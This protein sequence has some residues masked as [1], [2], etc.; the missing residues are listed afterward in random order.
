ME[1]L[2][3][4]LVT[5]NAAAMVSKV[6]DEYLDV[7]ALEPTLYSLNMTDSFVAYNDSGLSE[8]AIRAYISHLCMGLMSLVRVMGVLPII[9]APGG[10]PAEM[11]ANDLCGSLRDALSP[12]SQAHSI[13]GD[14]LVSDRPRP[15]LL[16]LDRVSDLT[17][18][19]MHASTY[20]ALVD[21]LLGLKLNKVTVSVQG[22]DQAAP[23]KKTYDLNS[24][25]DPFFRRYASAPFPEAV[26]ANREET[27]VV[28]K[29]EAEIRSRPGA[30]AASMMAAESAG[31]D[32][33]SDAI[34]SLPEIL[35]KKANLEA[36][37]SILQA[38]MREVAA[39]EVH[40]YFELEQTI[41]LSG[42][43]VD[44]VSVLELLRDG[45]KGSIEDKARLL[46]IVT[47][48]GT[49]KSSTSAEDYAAAF[50]EGCRGAAAR[51]GGGDAAA[52]TDVDAGIAR[53]TAAVSFLRRLKKLQSPVMGYGGGGGGGEGKSAMISSLLSSATSGATSLMARATAL[54]A[55]FS[56]LPVSTVVD[57]LAEGRAC[58]EDESYCYLDPRQQSAQRGG[59][60]QKYSEV[61]VF[62]VGGG[63]L[64]EYFNLQEMVQQKRGNGAGA[65]GS[66]ANAL[67]NVVY[68][69]SE[70]YSAAVFLE[71][72]QKLGAK[73]SG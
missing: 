60:G 18:P 61:V 43:S 51:M 33:L 56:P 71:Q 22:K 59:G 15:L 62:V 58:A 21:D 64:S 73:G 2:A 46:A 24:L 68:G 10:G 41:L 37:T 20:H 3:H 42:G 31:N 12:R 14:F 6:Y 25:T 13:Y 47:L 70:I 40:T 7:I 11:L 52:G 48:L 57:N 34:T 44:K 69:G 50:E 27:A 72:L 55:K 35:N 32:C 17:P 63:C 66:A 19:L 5:S 23:R 28:A 8:A 38:V 65:Q 29:R 45:S 26:E 39:R 54:F 30:A 53:M 67:R 49:D 16:I 4:G 9:R 1:N 36:H